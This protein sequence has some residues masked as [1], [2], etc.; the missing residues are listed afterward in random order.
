MAMNRIRNLLFLLATGVLISGCGSASEPAEETGAMKVPVTLAHIQTHTMT[1]YAEFQATSSFLMKGVIKAPFDGYVEEVTVSPG[2]QVSRNQ[3]LFRLKT[4]EARAIGADTLPNLAIRGEVTIRSSIAGTVLQVVHPTGDFVSQG[5]L[6]CEIAD[7]TSL[8]FLMDVPFEQ[9]RWISPGTAC[10]LILPDG[11]T[12]SGHVT[13]RM[14]LM[15]SQAQ[16]E[17]FQV[18]LGEPANLP[19]N[20]IAR[21]Q[22]V[23]EVFRDAVSLPKSCILADET[24]QHFWVMKMVN[25]TLAVKVPVTPGISEEGAIQVI[26]PVFSPT[27][28]FLATGNYGL[29]DTAIVQVQ[30]PVPDEH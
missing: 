2:Q 6:L 16:T 26:S 20:L 13:L 1:S 11:R 10:R 18:R 30:N 5:D 8:V 9:S 24:L 7:V 12:L 27:D 29:G 23:R 15:G 19:E 3:G 25:D 28:R 4:R 22:L 21:V 14:P 17:R